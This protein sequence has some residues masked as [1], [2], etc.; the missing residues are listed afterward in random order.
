MTIAFLFS[1]N[2][3]S[4]KKRLKITAML[5]YDDPIDMIGAKI[6]LLKSSTVYVVYWCC[7]FWL[8]GKKK[9]YR[10]AERW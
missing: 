5:W 10:H 9:T 4:Q 2:Q 6:S 8:T 3:G 1:Q 7:Y